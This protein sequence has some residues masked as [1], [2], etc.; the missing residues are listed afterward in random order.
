MSLG[1]YPQ[2]QPTE[3]SCSHACVAML[4]GRPVEEV[5]TE[6]G[7][8]GGLTPL[9]LM[10]VLTLYG[11]NWTPL[12]EPARLWK[13][14]QIATV[15]S[16]NLRAGLH[17]ILIH[18]DGRHRSVLDPSPKIRY[19]TDGTDLEGWCSVILVEPLKA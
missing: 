17:S 6:L 16:L 9:E 13:G 10:N 7:S 12:A 15:P 5:I 3:W 18:W 4:L 11:I 1:L 19:K 14:W 8:D 2:T